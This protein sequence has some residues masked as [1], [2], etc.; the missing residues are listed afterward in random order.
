MH[1]DIEQVSSGRTAPAC[2]IGPTLATMVALLA[3]VAIGGAG[4]CGDDKPASPPDAALNADGGAVDADTGGDTETGGDAGSDTG[5][6]DTGTGDTGA[7]DGAAP[8]A[9]A[10]GGPR[11]FVPTYIYPGPEWDRIIAAAPTVGIMVANPSDGPG[12]AADPAYTDAIA[13][14]QRAGISVLGYV[15]T[16]YGQRDSASVLADINAYY[17]LYHPSGIFLSEGPMAADC[18]SMEAA[19]LS[20]A[21]AA[22]ARDPGAFVALGT[23]YCP[24]YI[25]FSD[26]MVL[27]AQQESEYDAFQPASWM[28]GQ[29]A[30]RFAHLVSEVPDASLDAVLQRAHALGAGWMYVTDD[31]L[32]NPWDQLPS[33]FDR[34]VQAVSALK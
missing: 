8:A 7:G 17:D 29:S 33:Y 21:S 18:T 23:L 31:T 10:G 5:A 28:P 20:Y 30:D 14:A 2:G 22:R 3:A 15:A 27:F 32:P 34:E 1:G 11:L 26:L 9:A 24:S 13:R 16:N 19:F 25:Y 4:G 12:A 6:G